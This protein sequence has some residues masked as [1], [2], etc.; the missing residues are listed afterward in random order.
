MT[1][2]L[3]ITFFLGINKVSANSVDESEL[4]CRYLFSKPESSN[5]LHGAWTEFWDK[6][7]DTTEFIGELTDTNLG[8]YDKNKMKHGYLANTLFDVV[9]NRGNIIVKQTKS[10]SLYA[11]FSDKINQK[12]FY[13]NGEF[14]CPKAIYGKKPIQDKNTGRYVI[15]LYS[16]KKN[17]HNEVI[18]IYS[19]FQGPITRKDA[20]GTVEIRDASCLGVLGSFKNDLDGLLKIIRFVAP[21]MVIIYSTYDFL[22]AIFNKDAE[23]LGKASSRLRARL[24]LVAILFFLPTILNII[25]GI[26]DSSYTTCVY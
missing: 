23:L 26:I 21:L 14:S 12:T 4:F 11:D 9:D 8:F 7:S 22:G 6:V 19:L 17:F 15:T 5:A 2:L 10:S 16:E 13:D 1:L 25:L 20:S 18:Y 3:V 24:I